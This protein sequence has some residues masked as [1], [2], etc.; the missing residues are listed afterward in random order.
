MEKFKDLIELI[1]LFGIM[2][3]FSV[4]KHGLNKEN[5]WNVWKALSK[6]L[7]NVIAGVGF[8]SFLLSYNPWHG[9]YPQKIGVIMFV[10]Y[11][12]SRL[13]DLLVDKTLDG[14]R[15]MNIKELI[16]HFFKP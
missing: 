8:Y 6:F 9:E 1:F 16:K 14:L 4:L 12:G 3:I 11:I 7:V 15:S 13:I 2:G 5:K 10:T